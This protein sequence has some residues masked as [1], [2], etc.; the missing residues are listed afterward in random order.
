MSLEQA[1]AKFETDKANEEGAGTEEPAYTGV[2]A[3]WATQA[4]AW[5][6]GY[7]QMP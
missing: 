2:A 3:P 4:D 5:A 7:S 1:Q 6:A